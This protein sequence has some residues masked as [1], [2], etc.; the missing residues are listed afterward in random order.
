M[1]QG[2]QGSLQALW[3]GVPALLHRLATAGAR[4]KDLRCYKKEERH[5]CLKGLVEM[6]KEGYDPLGL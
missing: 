1:H 5:V 3:R 6:A 4:E 2:F